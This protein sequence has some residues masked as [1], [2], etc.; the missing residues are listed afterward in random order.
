MNFEISGSVIVKDDIQDISASFKKRE[1]VIEVVNE[2]NSDWNDFIKFQLTQDRCNLMDPIQLG[3]K[4]KVSFNIRGRKWEKDGRVNYFSNLE[5]WRI[6]KED[7][8]LPPDAPAPSFN[9]ADI[10]PASPEEDL[11]F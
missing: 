5:A 11:P 10:P 4:I 3:D 2:R 1:F 9:E 8:A 6:E 7:A